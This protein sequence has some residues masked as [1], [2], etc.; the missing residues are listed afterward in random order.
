MKMVV[1]RES[2]CLSREN[3]NGGQEKMKMKMVF[4]RE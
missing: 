4:K 1:N 2:K 3:E